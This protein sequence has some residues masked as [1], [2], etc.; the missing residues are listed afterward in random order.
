MI[1]RPFTV[2][3]GALARADVLKTK[4]VPRG[5]AQKIENPARAVQTAGGV[6][7]S[8]SSRR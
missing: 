1:N 3:T 2:N 7:I 6:T 5:F 4:K 8:I